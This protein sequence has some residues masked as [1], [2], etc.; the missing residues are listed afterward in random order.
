M[1]PVTTNNEAVE[2]ADYDEASGTWMVRSSQFVPKVQKQAAQL[3]LTSDYA[4]ATRASNVASAVS[5][6]SPH[7]TQPA[8]MKAQNAA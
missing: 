5:A 1:R 2:R 6:H 4:I 8:A 7:A 3:H